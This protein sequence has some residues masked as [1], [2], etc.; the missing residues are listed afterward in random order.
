MPYA[1]HGT[2]ATAF[3]MTMLPAI[4]RDPL[5]HLSFRAVD[6]NFRRFDAKYVEKAIR[7]TLNDEAASDWYRR[8]PIILVCS[9]LKNAADG[10]VAEKEDAENS[11]Q[12]KHPFDGRDGSNTAVSVPSLAKVAKQ[13]KGDL[14]GQARK[15]RLDGVLTELMIMSREYEMVFRQVVM[16]L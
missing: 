9:R 10:R 16:F 11:S 8:G 2:G 12:G 7:Y 13:A 1:M 5:V 4:P 14:R 6:I 3:V 15:G